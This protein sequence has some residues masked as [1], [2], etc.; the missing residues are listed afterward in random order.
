MIERWG[1]RLFVKLN[2]TSITLSVSHTLQ[3]VFKT[4]ESIASTCIEWNHTTISQY[5]SDR[6]NWIIRKWDEWNMEI[7]NISNAIEYI[8]ETFANLE[9]PREFSINR[10]FLSELHQILMSW[11]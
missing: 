10:L 9:N 8:H 1:T 6:H 4:I 3:S 2:K 7:E 11:L 5:I